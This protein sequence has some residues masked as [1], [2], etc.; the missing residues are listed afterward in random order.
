[1]AS[2]MIVS[3][4]FNYLPKIEDLL[5]S[6]GEEKKEEVIVTQTL[7]STQVNYKV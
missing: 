6:G 1:M 2:K 4:L 3:T 7:N 5:S